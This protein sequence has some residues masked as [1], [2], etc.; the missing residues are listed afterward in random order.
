MSTY[1]VAKFRSQNLDLSDQ[2]GFLKEYVGEQ[3]GRDINGS[4]Q[5]LA[6]DNAGS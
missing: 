4:H 1:V 3:F 5:R 6:D 2:F